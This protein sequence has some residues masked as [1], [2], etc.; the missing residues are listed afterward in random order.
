MEQLLV[1][2]II[3]KSRNRWFMEEIKKTKKEGNNEN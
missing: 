2:R 3:E 1:C